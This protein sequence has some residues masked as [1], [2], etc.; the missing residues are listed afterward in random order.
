M[1]MVAM[2]TLA[3]VDYSQDMGWLPCSAL[4]LVRTAALGQ[5]Q[6]KRAMRCERCER[7]TTYTLS[8]RHHLR[9]QL[10]QLHTFSI[11]SGVS[12]APPLRERGWGL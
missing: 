11:V 7:T 6:T 10:A 2:V 5:K 1:T 8:T 12:S 9:G 4:L 3:V